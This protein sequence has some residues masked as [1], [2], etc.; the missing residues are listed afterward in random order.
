MADRTALLSLVPDTPYVMGRHVRHDERSKQYPAA[1]AP[2]YQSVYWAHHGTTLNQGQIGSCTGNALVD[3][4]MSGPLYRT[5]RNLTE[6]DAVRAYSRATQLDPFPGVYPP[7]DTGSDGLDACKA[8]VEFGWLKGYTHAFGLDACLRALTLGPVMIGIP[9]YECVVPDTKVLTA[10]LEWVPAAKVGE[11]DRLVG[12]DE[13]VRRTSRYRTAT[14]VQSGRAVRPCYE[15]TTDRGTVTVTENHLFVLSSRVG[16]KSGL[17]TKGQRRWIRA[18]ALRP[19]DR[20][21]YFG[22]PWEV[23]RSWEAGWLAGFY[24]GEGSLAAWSETPSSNLLTCG[25]LPGPTMD[26]ALRFL[27]AKGFDYGT[28]LNKNS[29]VWQWYLRGENAKCRFLGSIRPERLLRVGHRAWEGHSTKAQCVTP[30][31]VQSIEAVG[32]EEVVTLGTST[33]TLV[34]D[35]LLSH[36]SMFTPG[37]GG[38][39]SVSGGVAGGHEV[40]LTAISTSNMVRI[41]NSW[42]ASWGVNGIAWLK[43]TDLSRLLSESGDV[44]VPVSV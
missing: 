43:F 37:S 29:G 28:K 12:F 22:D 38:V 42:G 20:L 15:V 34:T 2:T 39:L 36:N 8:G 40:A 1:L 5:G 6:K 24:D 27:S 9:W 4:L 10:D 30:A 14:V 33:G 31:V 26:Q 13:D 25:Q 21:T 32:D 41:Q 3:A 11:G 23:D 17:P 7:T 18:D 19:G 35:G 44:T 16:I